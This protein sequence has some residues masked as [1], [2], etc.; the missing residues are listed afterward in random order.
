MFFDQH[1]VVTKYFRLKSKIVFGIAHCKN[2]FCK[3]FLMLPNV[4]VLHLNLDQIGP[5]AKILRINIECITHL[6]ETAHSDIEGNPTHK[7]R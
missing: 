6:N 4:Y 5:A 2:S 3:H 7:S 1:L